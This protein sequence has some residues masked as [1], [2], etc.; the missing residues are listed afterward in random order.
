MLAST[1]ETLIESREADK[2]AIPVVKPEPFPTGNNINIPVSI[3]E[4]VYGRKAAG[5]EDL[6][7]GW[8][9]MSCKGKFQQIKSWLK[10]QSMLSKDQKKKLAQRKEKSP[11]EVP[12]ASTS[13]KNGKENPKEQ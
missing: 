4:L 12:Q 11:V 9:P 8:T 6:L 1:F 5:V 3:Q 2:T 7:R 13:A 10:N